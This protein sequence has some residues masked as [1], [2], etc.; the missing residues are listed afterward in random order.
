MTR[1]LLIVFI[2]MLAP[3]AFA[4]VNN[5]IVK[6][7]GQGSA[8]YKGRKADETTE[9]EAIAEAKRDA[10]QKYVA[11]FNT[12]RR[13][14]YMKVEAD[15]LK[16]L[17]QVVPN[18]T[19]LDRKTITSAKLYSVVVE[20]GIDDNF[21]EQIIQANFLK[22]RNAGSK[23]ENYITF[24]FVARELAV[25]KDFDGKTTK[26]ESGTREI[27]GSQ[28]VGDDGDTVSAANTRGRTIVTV[29]GGN[30]ESKA[31]ERKYRVFT[32]GEVNAAVNNILTVA[33][34]EVVNAVDAEL[35]VN[36]FRADYENGDDIQPETRIAAV[37][38]AKEKEICYLGTA[39]MDVGIP[40][41]DGATGQWRVYVTVNSQ[42]SDIRGRL[43]KTV[44]AI[45]GKA[46]AGLGSNK[47]VARTN[48][49]NTAAKEM[50]SE[51]VDQLRMKAVR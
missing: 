28:T 10:L 2:A 32:V 4:Q 26:I 46:Y 9:R 48:A 31:N 24:V 20:A 51:L 15:I 17:D 45:A 8:P 29:T 30:T 6:V 21:I 14:N 36:D 7:K 41:V 1:R 12:S 50:A 44:A 35:K 37:K 38:T 3:L 5:E 40:E 16:R 23:Q 47:Q 49:L 22:E 42:V 33:G 25:S 18:A 19:V 27:Q 11:Q 34:Y 13:A 39:S 43:A